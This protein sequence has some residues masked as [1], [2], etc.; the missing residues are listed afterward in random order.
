MT[1]AAAA[2]AMPAVTTTAAV[3]SLA[4]NRRQR[5][6]SLQP[7]QLKVNAQQ[8]RSPQ[9]QH[10]TAELQQKTPLHL[11]MQQC[12]RP[13]AN[14][15]QACS[16]RPC[17]HLGSATAAVTQSFSEAAACS[18]SGGSGSGGGNIGSTG[19]ACSVQRCSRCIHGSG[20]WAAYS[21]QRAHGRKEEAGCSGGAWRGS[22]PMAPARP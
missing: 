19:A 21:R 16:G 11:T 4:Q 3:R 18:S 7:Q 8:C 17:W 10:L 5:Q 2:A 13:A 20:V 14:Y 6:R 9:P 15:W 12:R 1:T 22:A